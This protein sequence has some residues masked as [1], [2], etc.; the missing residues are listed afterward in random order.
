MP[1]QAIIKRVQLVKVERMNKEDGLYL[2]LQIQVDYSPL[3]LQESYYEVP[4]EDTVEIRYLLFGINLI[5]AVYDKTCSS[6]RHHIH[7]AIF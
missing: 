2:G 7:V 4:A 5:F 3:G 1:V 6:G